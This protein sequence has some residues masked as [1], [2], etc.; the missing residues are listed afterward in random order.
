[1]QRSTHGAPDQ[2]LPTGSFGFTQLAT[3]LPGVANSGNA[4]ASFLLGLVNNGS[5]TLGPLQIWREW[6]YNAFLQDDWK[7]TPKLTINLGVRWDVDA[8]VYEDNDNGNGFDPYKINPVSGTP[9]V[10]TFLGQSGNP[11]SFYDTN[12]RRFGPRFGFAYRVS[13][14]TVLRGGYGIFNTSPILGAN[15]RRRI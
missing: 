1:M 6:Y 13:D 4:M 9:G 14:K 12:Y 7:V 10:V 8:P 11:S 5:T 2:S 15:R 3:S